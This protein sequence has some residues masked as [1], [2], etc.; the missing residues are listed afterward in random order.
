MINNFV[1]SLMVRSGFDCAWS[2][3]IPVD[4]QVSA[5]LITKDR[6]VKGVCEDVSARFTDYLE[7]CRALMESPPAWDFL[8]WLQD[9]VGEDDTE[10][11]VKYTGWLI[12]E[13]LHGVPVKAESFRTIPNTEPVKFASSV[14][15]VMEQTF[16]FETLKCTGMADKPVIL[17]GGLFDI[18]P[19]FAN[20]LS[21]DD[22]TVFS[23]FSLHDQGLS[24]MGND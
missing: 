22:I 23:R 11:D 1:W 7:A 9:V 2:I 5:Y 8:T 10:P 21:D 3:E 17:S 19:K 4:G 20:V 6:E 15:W 16:L 14:L 12:Q 18:Y 13:M 24:L